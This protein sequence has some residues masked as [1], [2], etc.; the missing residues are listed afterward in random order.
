MEFLNSDAYIVKRVYNI[1]N[2]EN[3]DKAEI[4]N[5]CWSECCENIGA[6]A[7]LCYNT[8]NL[9]VRLCAQ[10]ESP[11]AR[12][13]GLLDMVCNDS[14]LEFFFSPDDEKRYLNFEFNPK[15]TM[16]LGF[17]IDRYH[18]VRQVITGYFKIFSIMPFDTNDGWGIDFSIPHSFL[19]LYFP[20]FRYERGKLLRGNFYK[21]GN[22]TKT[23][24]Y[25]AWNPVVSDKP[26]FHRPECFGTIFFG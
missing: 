12:F 24:H 10:E 14:C 19:N 17:G 13:T 2:W 11:L 23:P 7:Q 22:E 6:Y 18:S 8:E 5:S 20:S 3:I 16:Y 15:G 21:C 25:L 26:D 1:P 9:M 4:K